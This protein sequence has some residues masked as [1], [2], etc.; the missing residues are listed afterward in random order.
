MQSGP[1]Q[2]VRMGTHPNYNET[3][4][5]HE[6]QGLKL[7][8]DEFKLGKINEAKNALLIASKIHQD[9]DCESSA[10]C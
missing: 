1:P 10:R 6:G 4:K 7:E 3:N 8:E 2:S 5:R 9:S